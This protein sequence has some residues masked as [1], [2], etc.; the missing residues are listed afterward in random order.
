M[1]LTVLAVSLAAEPDVEP[2]PDAPLALAPFGIAQ[3]AWKAP[4]RGALYAVTQAAGIGVGIFGVGQFRVEQEA[5]NL[6]ESETWQAVAGAAVGTAVLSYG[7]SLLD[8]SKLAEERAIAAAAARAR[9]EE[10]TDFDRS[11]AMARVGRP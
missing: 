4:V 1:L 5:G 9:R 3:M 2:L 11:L 7:V 6:A 8:G 10:V